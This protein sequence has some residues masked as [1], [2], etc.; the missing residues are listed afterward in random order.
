MII[1]L[2]KSTNNKVNHKYNNQKIKKLKI[3]QFKLTN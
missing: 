2:N 3:N 1:N